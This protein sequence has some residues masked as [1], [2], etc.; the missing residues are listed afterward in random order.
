MKL[1]WRALALWRLVLARLRLS[2]DREHEMLGNRLAIGVLVT[3]Y[4]AFAVPDGHVWSRLLNLLCVAYLT[5]SLLL[6][7]HPLIWPGPS[8]VRRILAIALDVGVLSLGFHLGGAVAS[9]LF[10]VYLW[11]VLGNGF[12]FGVPWLYAAAASSVAGFALVVAFTPYWAEN[13]PLGLGLIAGLVAIPLYAGKLIRTLS[14]ARQRAEA[15]SQAKSLFLASVSHELRTPLNAVVGMNALI[16]STRLTPEQSEMSGIIGTASK[17][18]LSLID[19][20]LDLSRIDAGQMPVT[21]ARFDLGD[22]LGEVLD[23]ISVKSIEKGLRTAL[24]I[25]ART[26]LDLVGD[27]GRLREIL[28]NLV[29]NAVKFTP[30]GFVVLTADADVGLDRSC[31]LRIEVSDSGIGI[32]PEAQSRIFDEFVQADGTIIDRFGGTGLGLTIA[33]RLVRLLGGEIAVRSASGRG[34]AFTISVPVSTA[35][36]SPIRLDGIVVIPV[37]DARLLEPVLTRLSGLGCGVAHHAGAQPPG[38]RHHVAV[39]ALPGDAPADGSSAVL[40]GHPGD[41]LPPLTLRLAFSSIVPPAASDL[42]LARIVRAAAGSSG[43]SGFEDTT[44]WTRPQPLRILLADDNAA[45]VRVLEMVLAR[46]G[47]AATVVRNG[48]EAL[49]AMEEGGFD[50]VLMDINMPVMTGIEAVKLHRLATIGRPHL[51]ILGLTADVTEE[52]QA[53]CREAGIDACLLKPIIPG[54]LLDALDA[55]TVAS[56]RRS[57]AGQPK[58]DLKALVTEIASHPRFRAGIAAP[59]DM[60]TVAQLRSLGGDQ[61]LDALIHDF[62]DDAGRIH[63][64]LQAAAR[65]S[66]MSVV[67]AEAHALY[68][69]AGNMGAEPVRQ[70]CRALQSLTQ[71]DMAGPGMGLLRDLTAELE[72][73][74]IALG[75]IRLV[76]CAP[77]WKVP[78]AKPGSAGTARRTVL[79]LR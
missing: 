16:A 77:G 37:G 64:A 23:I 65:T 73:A 61:F 1:G 56:V 46:A 33:S 36:P 76:G 43:R 45:N 25:T 79:P 69:A 41:E 78:P 32:A 59:I 51:P 24:H 13:L 68:S 2:G 15:A 54:V 28:L 42:E 31:L 26:P 4:A 14:Q 39:A 66:D 72:R 30:S 8:A 74:T 34:S 49:D 27:A 21:H 58:R 38:S 11:I 47:H 60:A 44:V 5:G 40:I 62:L 63:A 71:A 9:P 7:A 57:P 12:R 53:R 48:E 52:V 17:S 35:E 19:G 75:A 70:I 50:A 29:G 55:A 18:L 3:A 67:A 20:I 22:L 10:A 6:L